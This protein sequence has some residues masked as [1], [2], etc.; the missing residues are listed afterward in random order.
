MKTQFK[1]V[2][3]AELYIKVHEEG[4]E[5]AKS[6]IEENTLCLDDIKA[7]AFFKGPAIDTVM[8]IGAYDKVFSITG[9]G[10]NFLKH[11]SNM[12]NVSAEAMLEYL[13]QCKAKKINWTLEVKKD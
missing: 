6:F 3:E 8:L 13:I 7:G 10:G 2:A 1:S 12:Q 5:A 11:Y 9:L 4:I